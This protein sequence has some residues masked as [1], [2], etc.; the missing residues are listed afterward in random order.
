MSLF[1][2]V[3][4]A[5]QLVRVGC[6]VIR[7]HCMRFSMWFFLLVFFSFINMG[8]YVFGWYMICNNML[9]DLIFLLMSIYCLPLSPLINFALSM[10]H[11]ILKLLHPYCHLC[12]IFWYIFFKNEEIYP[13]WWVYFLDVAESRIMFSNLN[14]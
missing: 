4:M 12:S 9:M 6:E 2:F 13:S 7:Y 3:R 5:H 14:C 10:L 1:V 11:Q 8:A